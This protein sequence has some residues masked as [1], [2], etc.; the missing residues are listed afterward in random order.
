MSLKEIYSK[1]KNGEDSLNSKN[2][3]PKEVFLKEKE[4][5]EGPFYHIMGNINDS[6]LIEI[7]NLFAVADNL[8]IKNANMHKKN[9]FGAVYSWTTYFCCVFSLF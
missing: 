6:A 5:C 1:A 2:S 7:D 8:S 9:P 4:S 3:N